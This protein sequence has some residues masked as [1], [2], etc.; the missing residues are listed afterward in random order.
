MIR[1]IIV[2]Y[3]FI[4]NIQTRKNI[5]YSN[6]YRNYE[7]GSGEPSPKPENFLIFVKKN[8]NCKEKVQDSH[9]NLD[10]NY[11]T[12]SNPYFISGDGKAA[13][14]TNKSKFRRLKVSK[15]AIQIKSSLAS[16]ISHS[17]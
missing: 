15:I 17:F 8:E 11:D 13:N 9:P 7:G 1:N 10:Q 6:Q 2:L 12:D 5:N 3:T 4:K 16:I 14:Q